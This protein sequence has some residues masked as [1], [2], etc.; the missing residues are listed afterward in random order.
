VPPSIVVQFSAVAAADGVRDRSDRA[1]VS[2]RERCA[3][4]ASSLAQ[5]RP[6]GCQTAPLG[7]A[8]QT[9]AFIED[10]LGRPRYARPHSPVK[11][12]AANQLEAAHRPGTRCSS[13][14]LRIVLLTDYARRTVCA[15]V[16]TA[17]G[18][19]AMASFA[20]SPGPCFRPAARKILGGVAITSRD[21]ERAVGHCYRTT[22]RSRARL[23]KPS[24]GR[25]YYGPRP[26]GSGWS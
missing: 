22:A 8:Q 17:S 3:S 5:A 18:T 16:V 4:A 25:W 23:V 12:I 20:R 15:R 9:L 11:A 13:R 19:R 6:A 26:C 2:T 14:R 1:S 7:H 24:R 10:G 21:C